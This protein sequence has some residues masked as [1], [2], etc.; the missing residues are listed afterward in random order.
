MLSSV[1]CVSG[2][3][4]WYGEGTF[5]ITRIELWKIVFEILLINTYLHFLSRGSLK[6][7]WKWNKLKW[8]DLSKYI[9]PINTRRVF[10]ILP[11]LSAGPAGRTHATLV[12]AFRLCSDAKP[13][14]R[15][16]R[17]H[18]YH[19]RRRKRRLLLSSHSLHGQ[20]LLTFTTWS[21]FFGNRANL[22]HKRLN[23]K[24][25]F[26]VQ[27]V[28]RIVTSNWTHTSNRKSNNFQGKSFQEEHFLFTIFLLRA[29]WEKQSGTERRRDRHFDVIYMINHWTLS[30]WITPLLSIALRKASDKICTVSYG[31]HDVC[32]LRLYQLSRSPALFK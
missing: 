2:V 28:K 6:H 32:I 20:K 25:R 9:G 5:E 24:P 1:A 8:R 12:N 26:R 17:T 16:H 15:I 30:P 13:C 3:E 18:P 14:R 4:W 19:S 29:A 22:E 11:H 27:S 7:I 31:T 21:C 10:G 23:C